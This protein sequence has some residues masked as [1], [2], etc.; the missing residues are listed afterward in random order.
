MGILG[1]GALGSVLAKDL[2]RFGFHTQGWS[3]SE[4]NIG[5]VKTFA[6]IDE[7]STFL[8]TTE[9]LVCLLP[10]TD[11]TKGILNKALFMQL[12]EGAFVINVARGGHLVDADLIEM[13]DNG[14]LSGAALDVFHQ[15]PL[16]KNHPFWVHDKVQLTPHCASVSDTQSVVPQIL[17]NYNRLSDGSPLINLVSRDK[18]Y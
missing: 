1:L 8:S 4:K 7:L 2:V 13:L 12:P 6:G 14:K 16:D 18:G 3:Q 11:E 17:E 9:I 15:E 10:L 5:Q